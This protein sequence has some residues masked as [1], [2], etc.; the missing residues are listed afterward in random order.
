MVKGEAKDFRG[1]L[2][3][4][5]VFVCLHLTI[6]LKVIVVDDGSTDSTLNVAYQWYNTHRDTFRVISLVKNQGKGGAVKVGV[7]EALGNAILMVDADG[8]TDIE[9]LDKLYSELYAIDSGI[10][11][12]SLGIVIGSR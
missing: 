11:E 8:A 10:K 3:G 9:D 5:V 1:M 2:P 12:D 6:A 7:A 4:L